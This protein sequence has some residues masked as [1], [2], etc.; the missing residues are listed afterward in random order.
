MRILKYAVKNILRSKF[1]SLSIIIVI[2]LISFF[3][4]TL[5]VLEHASTYLSTSINAKISLTTY[6]KKWYT[7]VNSE[8]INLLGDLKSFDNTLEVKYISKD[9]AF[10][11]LKKRDPELARVVEQENENPLPDSISIKNIWTSQYEKVD[12]IIAKYK[13]VIVYDENKAKSNLV[14]Y[15]LQIE[16]V[17][18]I[19]GI[20][21]T[22]QTWIY[23]I[24]W[25]FLFAVFI[26]IYNAIS[27][28]VFLY[29]DE[30]IITKL[31]GWDD[32]FVFWPFS[33]QWFLYSSLWFFL[34]LRAFFLVFNWINPSMNEFLDFRESFFHNS[35][36]YFIQ[37]F[38][39]LSVVWLLS[40]FLSSSRFIKNSN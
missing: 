3:I 7:N 5:F 21:N 34:G 9:T 8:I 25:F 39:L 12:S 17:K 11:E 15:K 16:R 31:V 4:N 33:I 10:E 13:Q 23:A 37:E 22:V 6:L 36:V 27:N 20:L 18:K 24:I 1:L 28:F 30:I 29:R 35:S 38:L 2:C 40:W 14:D 32:L 26:I 19:V